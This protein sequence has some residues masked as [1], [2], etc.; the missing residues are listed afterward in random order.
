MNATEQSAV[1]GK[2]NVF[3]VFLVF[4]AFLAHR[5]AC[6]ETLEPAPMTD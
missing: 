5:Q 3:L 6:A 4:L 1:N 2:K